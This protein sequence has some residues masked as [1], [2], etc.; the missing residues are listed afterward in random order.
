MKCF[1]PGL[2]AAAWPVTGVR[3][4]LLHL[5]LADASGCGT[6]GDGE[7]VALAVS[8]SWNLEAG[9]A[10]R[11]ELIARIEVPARAVGDELGSARFVDASLDRRALRSVLMQS[12]SGAALTEMRL[13]AEQVS[14]A[15]R[16]EKRQDAVHFEHTRA[17][18]Q[19]GT[20]C[21]EV[22]AF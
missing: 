21:L 14:D 10:S 16:M 2:T 17:S 3:S 12:A 5:R 11:V 9:A 7:F 22:R 8:T 4:R 1:L 18:D 19:I 20:L 6:S 13:F 15:N